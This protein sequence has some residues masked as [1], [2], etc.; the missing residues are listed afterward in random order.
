MSLS[1]IIGFTAKRQST[2]T[3]SLLSLYVGQFRFQMHS[4]LNAFNESRLFV[5]PTESTDSVDDFVDFLQGLSVHEPVEF[6]EVGFDG[7]VIEAAGFVIGI[8]Q[9]LQDALGIVRI[10]WLL[11]GQVGLEDGH[12]RI[13]LHRQSP[14]GRIQA[15]KTGL[16]RG[17]AEARFGLRTGP[18]PPSP[19]QSSRTGH[20]ATP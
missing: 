1:P 15:Q 19:H 4:N 8:E 16:L 11:G 18:E 9:H 7:C 6:V 17:V 3:A 12:K 14:P 2:R 20:C 10:V 5:I 13:H